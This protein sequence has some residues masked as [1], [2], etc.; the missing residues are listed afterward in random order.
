MADIRA[1]RF[2]ERLKLFV[3]GIHTV[4]IACIISALVI[5]VIR[6]GETDVFASSLTW[7]WIVTGSG[8]HLVALVLLGL[9]KPED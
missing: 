5:P 2:N 1:K 6:E 8:L 9:L 3:S 7:Y 4:G